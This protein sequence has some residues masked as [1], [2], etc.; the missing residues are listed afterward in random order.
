MKE[1]LLVIISATFFCV[2]MV[3]FILGLIWTGISGKRLKVSPFTGLAI[4]SISALWVLY[5]NGNKV[6]W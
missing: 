6:K 4:G 1:G 2:G 3:Y 5:Y